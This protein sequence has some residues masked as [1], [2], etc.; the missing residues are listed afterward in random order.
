M[1]KRSLFHPPLLAE[2]DCLLM[3][4]PAIATGGVRDGADEPRHAGI[5]ACV[6]RQQQLAE[7]EQNDTELRLRGGLQ[8]AEQAL[9]RAAQPARARFQ[10]TNCAF[11]VLGLA[12]DSVAPMVRAQWLSWPQP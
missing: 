8:L 11:E 10:E 12:S 9:L 7:R 2:V 1:R 6:Q 4:L 5:M 3:A